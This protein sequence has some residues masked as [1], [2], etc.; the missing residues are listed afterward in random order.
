MGGAWSSLDLAPCA[1]TW[2]SRRKPAATADRGAS[3]RTPSRRPRRGPGG[4]PGAR[5][6][7][8]TGAAVDVRLIGS[9]PLDG[10]DGLV[11]AVVL[12]NGIRPARSLPAPSSPGLMGRRRARRGEGRLEPGKVPQMTGAGARPRCANPCVCCVW[13]VRGRWR[14]LRAR[15]G[16]PPRSGRR[17]SGC[18]SSSQ[19]AIRAGS[20][21]STRF[22]APITTTSRSR[23]AYS[24]SSGGMRDPALLV[25]R[26]LGGPHRPGTGRSHAPA[27][28]VSG[29]SWMR[30]VMPR[31]RRAGRR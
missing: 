14:R 22:S 26:V 3:P 23:P 10:A 19:A 2:A 16:R 13:L 31:S 1:A 11:A 4:G 15:P 29:A 30:S 28:T 18:C 17:T 9:T 6:S 7:P 27:V 8:A 20:Q 24:R 5:R 21:I 25:G 12:V